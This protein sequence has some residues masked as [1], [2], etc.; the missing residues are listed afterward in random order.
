MSS[1]KSNT[2]DISVELTFAS[3]LYIHLMTILSFSVSVLAIASCNAFILILDYLF[4]N[5]SGSLYSS[6]NLASSIKESND[7]IL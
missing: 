6:S 7:I 2:F 3:S 1:D 4:S 5:G